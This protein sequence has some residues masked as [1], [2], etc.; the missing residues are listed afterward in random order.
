MQLNLQ[1]EA[2]WQ[3][4]SAIYCECLRNVFVYKQLRFVIMK[5]TNRKKANLL[6]ALI[7]LLHHALLKS[8]QLCL[9]HLL[10]VVRVVRP[11]VKKSQL[12]IVI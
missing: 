6:V 7:P 9:R 1:R 5:S 8:V 10:R 4:M 12:S 11:I 3:A 2:C